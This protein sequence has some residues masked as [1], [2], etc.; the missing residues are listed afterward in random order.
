VPAVTAS[1]EKSDQWVTGIR[2]SSEH[3]QQLLCGKG[4]ASNQLSDPIIPKRV[5]IS[6]P[7]IISEKEKA[8]EQ[9]MSIDYLNEYILAT[10]ISNVEAF[11]L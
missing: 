10:E 6:Q 11:E 4:T 5:Q 8:A 9:I 2:K 3:I 7:F 1:P